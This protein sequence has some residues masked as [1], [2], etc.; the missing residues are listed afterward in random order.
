VVV[1]HP[2]GTFDVVRNGRPLAS[3]LSRRQVQT[4]LRRRSQPGDAV[5]KEDPDGYQDPAGLSDFAEHLGKV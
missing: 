4:M 3:G 2:D 5:Q 1:E